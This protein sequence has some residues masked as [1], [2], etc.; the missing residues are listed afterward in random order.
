MR[1]S[2]NNVRIYVAQYI[3][4]VWK[5]PTFRV[6]NIEEMSWLFVLSIKIA[7]AILLEVFLQKPDCT[8]RRS[9]SCSA[10]KFCAV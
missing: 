4:D 8:K 10:L 1:L 3:G 5:R 7:Y 2:N 9:P 6:E